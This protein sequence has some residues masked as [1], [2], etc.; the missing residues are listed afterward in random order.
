VHLLRSSEPEKEEKRQKEGKAA[1]V[2]YAAGPKLCPQTPCWPWGQQVPAPDGPALHLPP[3][4]GP[5]DP[6]S[7]MDE[8]GR[9]AEQF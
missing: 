8:A 5:S 7:G 2:A 4:R 3:L 9:A 1:D 6:S